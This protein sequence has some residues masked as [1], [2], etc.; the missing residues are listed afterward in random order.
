MANALT[1]FNPAYWAKEMQPIF[2]KECVALGLANAELL[3]HLRGDGYRVYKPYRS[4]LASQAYTKGTDITVFNDLVSTEEYLDVD[5]TRIVPFYV[6][7]LDKIQ[8]KWDAASRFAQDSQRVLNNTLDQAVL[9]E[10]TNARSF[11]SAQ[12]LGGSGTGDATISL[13][14][15]PNLFAVAARKLEAADVPTNDVR[16]VV[17]PRL[18][19]QIRLYASGR[20]TTF[21]D[22]VGDN[23]VVG[24]RFGFTIHQ[25]NNVPFTATITFG[26]TSDKPTNSQ[27][28][29]IDGVKFT[30][31]S[32]IG[33]AAGN[34][35]LET[36]ATDTM[37]NLVNAI[38]NTNVDAARWV[39]LSG[40]D[41]RRFQK[42]AIVATKASGTTITIV[43]YGDVAISGIG[44]V[45][46]FA[47][48]SNAQYPVFM[49][50]K[51][52]DLVTQKSPSV[53]FRV[54]E[55]RLGRYVYPWMYYGKKTFDSMKDGITYAKIDTSNWV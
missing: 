4:Y 41:R 29:S 21:G 25:S 23:G 18:M 35:K 33:T 53:E 50:N 55:K 31:L 54:A 11:I 20:E 43:G 34:I 13:S 22:T 39:Q 28:F 52:I 2:F 14:N 38:N 12:D 32:T 17:G 36:N 3:E 30:F 46:N 5:T 8:N 7:D 40:A 48:T 10:Y 47:L 44:D 24:K 15:I 37:T 26:S 9:A 51:A 19:E 1:A 42:H 27:H 45:A 6:D 16:A 49:M